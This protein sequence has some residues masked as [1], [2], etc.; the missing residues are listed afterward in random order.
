MKLF[1]SR[2][3]LLLHSIAYQTQCI[4]LADLCRAC[5]LR[6]AM[7]EKYQVRALPAEGFS[8]TGIIYGRFC[9]VIVPE[10]R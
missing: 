5:Y 3:Q 2:S 9:T 8:K 10:P 1:S 4:T 6:F 7:N